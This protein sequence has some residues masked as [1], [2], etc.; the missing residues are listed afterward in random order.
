L[1]RSMTRNLV[2]HDRSIVPGEVNV[3][4]ILAGIMGRYPYGGV[5][6]CSLM[7]LIGLM[8]MGHQVWYLEDMAECNFD[9]VEN[10]LA[11]NPR[12]ALN[13]IHAC[14][15]PYGLGERWCYVDWR[16]D[17]HGYTR[18]HW[19]E[20]C[21][22]ADLF[23]NLSGGC[24]LW[25]DEYAA[26]PY[27]A[28]IDTDPGFTQ[29]D[30]DMRH[31]RVEFLSGYGALF[32]FGRNIGTPASSVPTQDLIWEHTWQ[33]VDVDLWRPTGNPSHDAFTT[34]MTW[35]IAS[36]KQIGGN[37]D[38]EFLRFLDLPKQVSTPLEL[39]VN[40]PRELL[41]EHGW[42]CRDAFPV[43]RTPEAYHD[44]IASSL[45]E[46]S[47]AKHTY[48]A[49]NSGWFSDRTECYLATGR[50]AV[51]QDT[52]FSA[53][54]PTGE[55][56][57]AFNTFEEA[58]D[59]LENVASDYRRHEIAARDLAFSHFASQVVLPPLLERATRS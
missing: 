49:T 14:L 58:R 15:E 26:I 33:P 57:L 54:L 36:F 51:V 45:G 25:R 13:F 42:R 1:P 52:G 35:R 40:G 46:F 4:I 5:A 50:P 7:Y 56:L 10:T 9:P 29:M 21:S 32:T 31:E 44:Y 17:Y 47:V 27:S 41:S 24:W 38:V 2:P 34:V 3:N 48:V 8:K 55:G 43:S 53:H 59:A 18:E 12:Y 19:L 22:G 39:A 30:A 16:Q 23:I 6:W 37:K 11:R 20:V 28:Y